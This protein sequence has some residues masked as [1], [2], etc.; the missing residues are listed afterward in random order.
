MRTTQEMMALILASCIE[1]QRI[2]AV[3]LNGSRAN[4]NVTPER[5]QGQPDSGHPAD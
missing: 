3:I 5:D 2:W 4:T 1:D